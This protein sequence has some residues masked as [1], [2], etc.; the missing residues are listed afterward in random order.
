MRFGPKIGGAFVP[1][2]IRLQNGAVKKFH[3]QVRCDNPDKRWYV[4]GGI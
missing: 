3:L 1:Y 4:D 2:E